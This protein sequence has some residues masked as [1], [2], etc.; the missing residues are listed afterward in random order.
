MSEKNPHSF[1]IFS[2]RNTIHC[3]YIVKGKQTQNSSIAVGIFLEICDYI[4]NKTKP[5]VF[6]LKK[7]TFILMHTCYHISCAIYKANIFSSFCCFFHLETTDL[8]GRSMYNMYTNQQLHRPNK[9]LYIQHIYIQLFINK[10][11][12]FCINKQHSVKT[13][14][15]IPSY[16]KMAGNFPE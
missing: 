12:V 7:K 14:K 8:W 4:S 1:Q 2:K 9:T 3:V 15:K 16:R 13:F 6:T 10:H 5:V 11:S